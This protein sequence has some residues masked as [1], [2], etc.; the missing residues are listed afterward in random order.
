MELINTADLRR[1]S[2]ALLIAGGALL[3][4]AV[5]VA[6]GA[7]GNAPSMV[8]FL[9]LSALSLSLARLLVAFL[10]A[11]HDAPHLLEP[12]ESVEAHAMGRKGDNLPLA[13]GYVVIATDRRLPAIRFDEVQ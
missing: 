6:V 7:F 3:A 13:R 10:R 5:L 4:A 11:I 1:F 12:G 2:V 8:F 9:V